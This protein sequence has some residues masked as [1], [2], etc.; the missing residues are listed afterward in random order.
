VKYLGVIFIQKMTWGLHIATIA[1]KVLQIFIS[2]YPILKSERLSVGT[3]LTLYRALVISVLTCACSTWHSYLLKLKRLQNKVVR[4]VGSLSR[5][6][7]SQ[8]LHMAF[9]IPYVYDFVTNY[10]GSR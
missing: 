8:D 2:I 7:P 5:C 6:I 1:T 4:T 10:A 9:K 3:E